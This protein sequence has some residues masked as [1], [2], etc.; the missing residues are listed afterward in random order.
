MRSSSWIEGDG[1]IRVGVDYLYYSVAGI[2][3]LKGVVCERIE[4]WKRLTETNIH[5][6]SNIALLNIALVTIYTDVQTETPNS[7]HLFR[8]HRFTDINTLYHRDIAYPTRPV[9]CI[10][11]QSCLT[12]HASPAW[13]W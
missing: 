12:L 3:E 8:L 13:T 2:S 4:G 6:F 10:C 7:Y 5:K 11:M 1:G 9:R